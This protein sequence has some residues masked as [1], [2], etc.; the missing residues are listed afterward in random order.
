VLRA[1]PFH[2]DFP[3]TGKWQSAK[4][5]VQVS[6]KGEQGINFFFGFAAIY[7]LFS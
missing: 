4:G 2:P 6:G 7:T 3:N 5:K 1:V